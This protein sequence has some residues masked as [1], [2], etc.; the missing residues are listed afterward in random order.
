MRGT[1]GRNGGPEHELQHQRIAQEAVGGVQRGYR[2]CVWC[3]PVLQASVVGCIDSY[4]VMTA[5]SCVKPKNRES[6]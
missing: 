2:S 1:G 6:R 4:E 3:W 5:E